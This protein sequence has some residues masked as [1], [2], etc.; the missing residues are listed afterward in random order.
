MAD[1]LPEPRV[2][3]Q[4][5]ESYVNREYLKAREHGTRPVLDGVDD[6]HQLAACIY[7]RG[8][9]DGELAEACR[10]DGRRKRERDDR[11]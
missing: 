6:L 4:M 8:F 11:D 7:A 5:V 3:V 10:A 1:L 9:A 2:V